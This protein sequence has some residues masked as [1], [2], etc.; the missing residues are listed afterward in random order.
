MITDT[1][2]ADYAERTAG[3]RPLPFFETAIGVTRGEDGTGRLVIDLGC[4]AGVEAQGFL[5]RGW[6]VFAVDSEPRA[7][8]VLLE[9]T[10]AEHKARLRTVVG[11][12]NEVALPE[13]DLVYASLSLPF[14]GPDFDESVQAALGAVAPG[15]WFVGVFLG[16][17]DTWASE[18]GV[19]IVDKSSLHRLLRGFEEVMVRPSEFDG[20]SGVGP[21]HWHWYVVSARRPV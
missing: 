13:A 21:K 2:W 16:P 15:G 12:F 1:T 5:D 11:R 10:P 19:A 4:G 17:N 7:V 18:D 9:A 14:A 8:E 6:E 20:D 3:R